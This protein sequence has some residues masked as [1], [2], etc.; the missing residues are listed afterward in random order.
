MRLLVITQK[1]DKNDA[2]LGFFHN[3]LL[4]FAENFDNIV[5]ICLEKGECNLPKNVQV[6]SLDKENKAS[7][8]QYISKFYQYIWQERK[9]YD[10][11]FVH[12]NQEYVLLGSIFWRIFAKKIILWRNHK[13]GNFLT[14]LAVCFAN[15][16][17]C[18]SAE[19]FT[20]KFQKTQIMPVGIDTDI[21]NRKENIEKI[22]KSILFL[23][24][25]NSIKNPDTLLEALS[26]LKKRN[27][28]FYAEFVGDALVKDLNFYQQLKTQTTKYDLDDRVKWS[29]AVPNHQTPE[30]YNKF[31][32]SVNLTVSGSLD[33]T[34]FEAMACKTLILSSNSFLE[35]IVPAE[36]FCEYKNSEQLADRLE[37]ILALS[38][39]E[40][41]NYAGKF[42]QYVVEN[43][44]LNLLLEKIKKDLL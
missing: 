30:I 9:N 41:I 1:V 26:V 12:M 31:L 4:K 44:S 5:V 10:A 28:N 22:P 37:N 43:H 3:W 7:R 33:K 14:S 2:V 20:A 6:L 13:I 40:Q 16:V 21:F 23:S 27:I 32:V 25:V 11:V 29:P 42:R 15:K 17:Y 24:R 38:F 18:T 19:S 36:F 35:K 8:W 34:I 39:D